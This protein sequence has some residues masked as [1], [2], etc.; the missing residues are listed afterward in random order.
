MKNCRTLR[1]AAISMA[2]CML[3]SCGKTARIKGEVQGL[4]DGEVI[5]KL[6]DINT[7]K[8]LD[9]LKTD[10][11]GHFSYKVPVADGQPEFVYVFHN[12]TKIAS[13]LLEKGDRVYVTA[14]T[15]GIF[16]VDGSDESVKLASVEKD[17]ADFV[18]EFSVFADKLAGMDASSKEADSIRKDMVKTYTAYYRSRV[19]YILENSHS[20]TTVPVLYQTV[21]TDFPIFSQQTDA[22]HFNN[23]CDSLET[24]Y[25]DSKYVKA[26]RK[27]AKRRSDLLSLSIRIENA[28][29]LSYPDLELPDTSA[30]MV[31]LSEVDAK[32]ILLHFWTSTDAAQKMFNLD[33]L[34]PIYEEFH[35]RGLEIY[36]VALDTDKAQW[37]R[38]V[39]DQGLGWINVCEG[40]GAGSSSL[41]LY[42]LDKLPVSFVIADGELVDGKFSDGASLRKLLDS[43]L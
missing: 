25:P 37:A 12:D 16:S 6:L 21:G 28:P 26:L 20:L 42:N 3:V 32:V 40:L 34:K 43:L 2:V 22:I 11:S 41:A 9:T 14:D 17:F 1:F 27:E 30:K 4:G 23:I 19:K 31:K 18:S 5:V 15:T 24:V 35:S 8:V 39:K 38:T 7:Y 36:Q 13:L 29:E 33:V 10:A